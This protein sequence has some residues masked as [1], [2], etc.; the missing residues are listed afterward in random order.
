MRIKAIVAYDGTAYGGWQVQQNADT[1]QAEMER[2]YEQIT[3]VHAH[4]QCAGRTDA[5]VHAL[6]QTVHFDI[7]TS[8]PPRKLPFVFNQLLPRDIRMLA[9]E[10]APEGFHACF[11][12]VGKCYEYRIWNAPHENP[13]LRTT[14][15]HVPV[16]LDVEKMRAVAAVLTGE[17]DFAAFCAAGAQVKTTVRTVTALDV[18][19]DGSLITLSVR[20]NGFLY[21]MVRILAGT[22]IL[23]GEGKFTPEQAR[24][25]LLSG[26]RV[27]AGFTAEPQ[28][29]IL[30]EVY[31][32]P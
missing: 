24:R 27:D 16:P 3:G 15:L 13:L 31:Y 25:A 5:G 8:I 12:A 26:R 19:Q 29:L 30:K 4:I 1:V 2:A 9:A 11:S 32:E 17:H 20:G 22:L 10:E 14:S 21:N 7:V 23:A 6:G 18:L 28:G